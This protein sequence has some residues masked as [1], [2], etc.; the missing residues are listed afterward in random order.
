VVVF[1]GICREASSRI[2]DRLMWI[3]TRQ[4]NVEW[5]DECSSADSSSDSTDTESD[6]E[7]NSDANE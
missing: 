5:N 4:N 7:Q 1:A 3:I 6:T 2:D